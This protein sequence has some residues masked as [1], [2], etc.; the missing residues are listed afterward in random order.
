[1]IKKVEELTLR[2]WK[3][4][5]PNLNDIKLSINRT[6]IFIRFEVCNHMNESMWDC[7]NVRN[8]D[9]DIDTDER[10]PED[11]YTDDDWMEVNRH[12]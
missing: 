10:I 8:L 6:K 12:A 9:D 4:I 5:Y 11:I 2:E 3:A 1:M 7:L